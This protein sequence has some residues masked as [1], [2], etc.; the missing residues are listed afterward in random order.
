MSERHSY[1]EVLVGV[2]DYLV[3]FLVL[4]PFFKKKNTV[5]EYH[6]ISKCNLH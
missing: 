3:V 2:K 5:H 4:F 1:N 6:W